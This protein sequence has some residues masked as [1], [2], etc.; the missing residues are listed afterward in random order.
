VLV[1]TSHPSAAEDTPRETALARRASFRERFRGGERGFVLVW[2]AVLMTVLMG[3]AGLAVDLGNWYLHIQHAQ[4]AA[5]AAALDGVPFLPDQ[6]PLGRRTAREALVRNQIPATDVAAAYASTNCARGRPC[7]RQVPGHP[8]QL[9]VQ[10]RTTATNLFLRLFKL[11]ATQTFSRHAIADFTPAIHMEADTCCLGTEP[12]AEPK[13]G[14]PG[15]QWSQ[16]GYRLNIAG[17]ATSKTRGDRYSSRTCASAAGEPIAEGCSGTTNREYVPTGYDYQ[18]TVRQGTPIDRVQIQAFDP[19]FAEVG[20]N[21]DE[22]GITALAAANPDPRYATGTSSGYCWADDALGDSPGSPPPTTTFQVFAG[23]TA[24]GA[25]LC[26]RR[27]TGTY[28]PYASFASIRSWF[29]KWVVLCTVP[30]NTSSVDVNF[31]VRVTASATG[32]GQNKFSL[33]AG[34]FNGGVFNQDATWWDVKL[35]A[36]DRLAIYANY[37]TGGAWHMR[38]AQ[39][40]SAYAG[41][42]V[43]LQLFDV[44]DATEPGTFYLS[45]PAGAGTSC[46]YTPATSRS[47]VNLP[48]C[49][50]TGVSAASGWNGKIIDVL[51]HVSPSYACTT[52]CWLVMNVEYPSGAQVDDATTWSISNPGMPI[53]LVK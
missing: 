1:A 18:V 45:T 8:T 43:H 35:W 26:T 47:Y 5:D 29:R 33:R 52:N 37:T 22:P 39:I 21:C 13:W 15:L 36:I 19:G 16:R 2:G 6:V 3:M 50:I 46:S 30:A 49:R 28:D 7:I 31:T 32:D 14:Q 41:Q 24:T 20:N 17:G 42:D 23:K 48:G 12:G 34:G 53:R 11:G 9:E 51:L 44:G 38:L 27:F 10:V 25:P 40:P 4:R